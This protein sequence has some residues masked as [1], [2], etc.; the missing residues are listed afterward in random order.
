MTADGTEGVAFGLYTMTGR[1]LSFIAPFMFFT[2]IDA[3]GTDR[4]GM[5]GLL[6]MLAAGLVAMV[7]VHVPRAAES[8]KERRA[9]TDSR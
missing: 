1:A 5:G 9:R 3:F 4:A 7:L 2:F 6:V 8:H